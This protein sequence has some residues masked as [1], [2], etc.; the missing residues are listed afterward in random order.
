[1]NKQKNT[2]AGTPEVPH[3]NITAIS[4]MDRES[5]IEK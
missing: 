1:L 2:N 4:A 3:Q 5:F